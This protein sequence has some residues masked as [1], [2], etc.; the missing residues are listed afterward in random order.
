MNVPLG[1]YVPGSTPLHRA[2]AGV[3]LCVIIVWIVLV[4]AVGTTPLRALI[5]AAI[6]ALVFLIA[7]IPLRATASQLIPP[8]PLIAALCAYQWWRMGFAT[9]A[10]LF[11][12]LMTT[13][14]AASLLTLTTRI[15]EIM[16]ALDRG[17]RPLNRLGIR[18]E[19]FSLTLA[20]TL[21]LIPLQLATVKDALEARTARGVTW[22]LTAIG[23]PVLVRSIRRARALSEALQ[24]RGVE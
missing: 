20:L 3:K 18:S 22:S 12:G 17:L 24:A 13:I 23:V 16:D 14:A 1:L 8:I 4:I 9:A 5:F 21:R 19:N 7:R 15:A 10:T 2:P 6:T 11:V